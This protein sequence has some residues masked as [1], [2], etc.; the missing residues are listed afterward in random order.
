MIGSYDLPRVLSCWDILEV[1]TEEP[2]SW[3]SVY[4]SNDRSY[5]LDSP[6]S[7]LEAYI[8][9]LDCVDFDISFDNNNDCR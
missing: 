6:D 8:I 1:Y 2:V 9:D 7:I 4:D 3:L 5:S